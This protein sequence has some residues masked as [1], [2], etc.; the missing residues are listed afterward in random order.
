VAGALGLSLATAA[1]PAEAGSSAA[2]AAAIEAHGGRGFCGTAGREAAATALGMTVDD[3]Q[4][5]MRAGES[6]ADLADEAGVDVS[7]VLDAIEAACVQETRDAIEQAVT[8]GDL[9]R[10]HADWLLEGL[11]SG[12]WGPGAENGRGFG[13][14]PRGGRG[15]FGGRGLFG[16][17]APRY[18][19]NNFEI[20]P[21]SDA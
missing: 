14:G 12:F 9:T 6:L 4:D 2:A 7:D 17:G 5:Q 18:F 10:E 8:D 21:G 19:F 3:M 1:Q 13:I 16:G 11:D 20:G 15:G